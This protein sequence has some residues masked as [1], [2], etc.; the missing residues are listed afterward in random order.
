[1]STDQD[2]TASDEVDTPVGLTVAAN[3]LTIAAL[4]DDTEMY[5]TEDFTAG[6]F[7]ADFEHTLKINVSAETGTE[8]CYVWGLSNETVDELGALISADKDTH[9]LY[10][11]N[12]TLILTEQ[13]AGAAAND[14][15]SSS[16]STDTDYYLRVVRD[17]SL[18]TYGTLYCYIYTDPEYMTIVDT[19]TVTLT[20]GDLQLDEYPYTLENMR[21]RVRDLLNESTADFWTDAMLNR[22]LNDGERD[23]AIKGLCLTHI[24]SISTTSSTRTVAYAAYRAL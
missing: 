24:D 18:G 10:W 19:L 1:M 14:D 2:Y 15:T 23:V 9:A 8:V 5:L 13:N 20:I 21:L 17:E 6:Y 16:L 11:S 7:S 4:D 12:A 22:M 3:L